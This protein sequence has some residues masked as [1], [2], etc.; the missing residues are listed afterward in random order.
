MKKPQGK[1]KDDK[2]LDLPAH[3]LCKRL[4]PL[5]KLHSNEQRTQTVAALPVVMKK[6]T[7]MLQ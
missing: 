3:V 5:N 2:R 1:E 6:L 7:S 4:V